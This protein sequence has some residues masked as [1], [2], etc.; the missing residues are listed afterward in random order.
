MNIII[1]YGTE[2]MS[3]SFTSTPTISQVIGSASVKAELGFGDNVKALVN[4]VEQEN[5]ALVEDGA[6]IVLETKANQK[7]KL[8]FKV[9][10]NLR[11]SFGR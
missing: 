9:E 10:F 5:S 3:K 11:L 2:T 6:L 7:A 8:P 1:R 4:G